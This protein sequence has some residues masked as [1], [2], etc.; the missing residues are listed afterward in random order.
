VNEDERIYETKIEVVVYSRGP[1]DHTPP[2][3]DNYG[4][5]LL[6]DI[7]HEMNDG[8]YLGSYDVGESTLVPP[9]EIKARLEAIGGELEFFGLEDDDDD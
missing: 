4:R 3:Y 8:S 7:L 9:E 1:V 5:D 6:T 2:G